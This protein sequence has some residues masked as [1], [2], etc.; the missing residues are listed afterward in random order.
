MKS[1][2]L[3]MLLFTLLFASCKD[4]KETDDC[5]CNSPTVKSL[6]NVKGSYLDSKMFLLQLKSDDLIFE[7]VYKLCSGSDTLTV[8]ADIT[9]PDYVLSGKVKTG[10]ANDFQSTAPPLLLEVTEIKKSF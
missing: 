3:K 2:Y 6:E 7:E 4:K 5:G 9:K 10:C 8:T 1:T